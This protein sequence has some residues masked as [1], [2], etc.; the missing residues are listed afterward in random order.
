M[1]LP[2]KTSWPGE[3]PGDSEPEITAL[4]KTAPLPPS[5]P[6]PA[7]LTSPVKLVFSASVPSLTQAPPALELAAR[8]SSRPDPDL[9][10]QPDPLT[11]PVRTTLLD[12]VLKAVLE[13]AT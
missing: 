5:V 12:P 8:M 7:T 10:K 3:L 4:P 6:E 9:M 2:P 13:P 11:A 1:T